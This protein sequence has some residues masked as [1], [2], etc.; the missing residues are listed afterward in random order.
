MW[1]ER[2]KIP[3]IGYNATARYAVNNFDILKSLMLQLTRIVKMKNQ[4]L[5]K[6]PHRG[7]G[8]KLTK[9]RHSVKT[10]IL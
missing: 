10:I 2:I 3:K 9:I 5:A 8:V 4:D 1:T 6:P 7:W